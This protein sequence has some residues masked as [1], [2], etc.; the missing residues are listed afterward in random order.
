M[1]SHATLDWLRRLKRRVNARPDTE[2]QQALIRFIIGVI[3]YAYFSSS[4]FNHPNFIYSSIHFVALF[5]ITT[6][7][8]ILAG[9]LA[10][11][12][13]SPVRRLFGAIVDFLTASF[14]LLMGARP[15]R[16]WWASTSG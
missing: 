16:R 4:W 1:S 14:L 5:F 3:S 8:L 12:S 13:V 7:A 11:P 2:F 10:D 6:S 15:R 9:T